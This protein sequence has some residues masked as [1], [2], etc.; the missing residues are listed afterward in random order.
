M[1]FWNKV[2]F[3][4][5][6][7]GFGTQSQGAKLANRAAEKLGVNHPVARIGA[8]FAG[9]FVGSVLGGMKMMSPMAIIDTILA[10]DEEIEKR[11]D[12]ME[13]WGGLE[14]ASGE[15]DDD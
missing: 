12:D 6:Y 11:I 13:P 10:T 14:G 3:H 5:I 9:A 8:F 2:G 15:D 1:G 7:N 4:F